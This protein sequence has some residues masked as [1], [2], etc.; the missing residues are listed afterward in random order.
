MSDLVSVDNLD[1]SHYQYFGTSDGQNNWLPDNPPN[2]PNIWSQQLEAAEA[3]GMSVIF[4]F[5]GTSSDSSGRFR[6]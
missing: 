2:D 6:F 4:S 1:F 3:P 5:T